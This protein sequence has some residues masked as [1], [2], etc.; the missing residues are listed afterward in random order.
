MTLSSAYIELFI[1]GKV[2][3]NVR[4]GNVRIPGLCYEYGDAYLSSYDST[5]RMVKT[6]IRSSTSLSGLDE[7][8]SQKDLG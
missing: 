8:V 5:L 2:R 3:G 4:G 1:G 6:W 7:C